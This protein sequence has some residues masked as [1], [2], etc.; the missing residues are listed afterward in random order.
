MSMYYLRL[1]YK[2]FLIGFREG[3]VDIIHEYFSGYC[4]MGYNIF[5]QRYQLHYADT[6]HKLF[7]YLPCDH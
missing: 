3:D 7:F 5:D 1:S 2:E 6:L 4:Q